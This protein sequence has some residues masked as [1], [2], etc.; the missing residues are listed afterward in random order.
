MPEHD[1]DPQPP[2]EPLRDALER[3][4]RGD[5]EALPALRAAL[6][7]HPEIWLDYGDLAD[8]AERA[9]SDLIAG[10]DLALAESLG[11]KVAALKVELA[12]PAPTPLERL[13]AARVAACWLQTHYADAAMAQAGQVSVRQEDLAQKRQ[14]RAHKSYLTA[15]AALATVRRLLPGT[16]LPAGVPEVAAGRKTRPA[17][18]VDPGDHGA[19]ISAVPA[20]GR[21]E[22]VPIEA[23]PSPGTLAL[24]SR[25]DSP[26]GRGEGL[27]HARGRWGRSSS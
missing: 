1:C 21:E 14:A 26:P 16:S 3:T 19:A 25:A 23:P 6:D 11:R 13:L 10:P 5:R 15:I 17:A 20:D 4:R 7:T 12:G 9:W 8:H 18:E 22:D 24:F 2:A 27:G